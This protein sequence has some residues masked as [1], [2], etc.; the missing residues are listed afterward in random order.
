MA[1]EKLRGAVALASNSPG[2]STGYGV[3]G[4]YLV[5]RMLKHGLKV[6]AFSNYGLEGEIREEKTRH[7]KYT[8]YPKGFAQYSQDVILAW[9]QHF[10]SKPD[11]KGLPSA[12]LTL[13]DVWIYD[14]LQFEGDILSWVPLDHVTLPPGVLKFLLR[15]N[16]TPITMSPH[17]QRQLEDAGIESTYIPHGV[18]TKVF[19][20]TDVAYGMPVREYLG[21][22]DDQFLVGM[23]AAN[24]ANG[25]LHRKAV[26]E[27]LLAFS[28]FKKS[29]PDAV[30][31][32]HMEASNAFGGFVLPRLLKAVGLDADSVIMPDPNTLRVG[33][34]QEVLAA[35]MSACDVGLT[36]SYGE[37]F[38]VPQVELQ[39]C[40]TPVV[41]SSWAASPDLAG[42]DSFLVEGQLFWDEPQQSFYQI[43]ILGS[44][45]EALNLAYDAPRGVSQASIDFAKQFDVDTVW[46]WYWMKFLRQYFAA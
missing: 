23:F 32:L 21:V 10:Q 7:G 46:N 1:I 19:K 11:V 16:V 4:Q 44:I 5:E 43:P 25:I 39:S 38:G 6:A 41:A 2:V 9:M 40:G 13:Y 22:R 29:H 17:G 30:L 45:V 42:P 35:F 18:D 8:H 33:Y 28:L 14:T 12:L 36:V 37:G 34:P 15:R 3:Q 31:Y 24:K 27:N 20:P 26:A